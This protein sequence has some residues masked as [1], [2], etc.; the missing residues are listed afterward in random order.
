L[1]G[2]DLLLPPYRCEQESERKEPPTGAQE[3]TTTSAVPDNDGFVAVVEAETTKSLAG[4][5]FITVIVPSSSS[6]ALRTSRSSSTDVVSR[7]PTDPAVVSSR[8]VLEVVDGLV[9]AVT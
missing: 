2:E 9:E 6:P 7:V 8:T 5:T 1:L 4:E 3:D